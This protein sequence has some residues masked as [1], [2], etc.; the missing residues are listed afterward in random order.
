MSA[1]L[2]ARFRSKV[3]QKRGTLADGVAGLALELVSLTATLVSFT[4]LGRQLGP[5]EYGGLVAMYSLIGIAICLA[6]VGPGLALL[7]VGMQKNLDAV[8]RP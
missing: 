8:A 4:L 6:Y 7:Q 5:T 1:E 3:A 2:T